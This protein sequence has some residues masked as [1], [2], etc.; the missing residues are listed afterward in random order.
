M[1]K[2]KLPEQPL[3]IKDSCSPLLLSIGSNKVARH[4]SDSPTMIP[5]ADNSIISYLS[6]NKMNILYMLPL[7]NTVVAEA[8]TSEQTV[9][10]KSILDL[11]SLV[12]TIRHGFNEMMES[13]K[14]KMD[15]RGKIIDM[16][17][18]ICLKKEKVPEEQSSSARLK[19]QSSFNVPSS[20]MLELFTVSKELVLLCR[21]AYRKIITLNNCFKE[22]IDRLSHYKTMVFQSYKMF[23]TNDIFKMMETMDIQFYNLLKIQSHECC[24]ELKTFEEQMTKEYMCVMDLTTSRN[25]LLKSY[26]TYFQSW[27]KCI[28]KMILLNGINIS[29][30]NIWMKHINTPKHEVILFS[31]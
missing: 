13:I 25:I 7:I 19:D 9:V 26:Q 11:F 29:K 4:L 6:N 8:T 23:E 14:Q 15:T 16:H 12:E 3:D 30:I 22:T 1:M 5:L 21:N 27:F 17:F 18:D 28:N 24:D 2:R 31:L 10:R 20:S